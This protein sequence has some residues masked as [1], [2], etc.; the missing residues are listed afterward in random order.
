MRMKESLEEDKAQSEDERKFGGGQF[1]E[2]CKWT[3]RSCIFDG[4]E[5]MAVEW[6]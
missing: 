1:L 5:S 4:S 2:V 6:S 3:D